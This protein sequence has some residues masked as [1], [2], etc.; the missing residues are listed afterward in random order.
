MQVCA[1]KPPTTYS[2]P[3][4]RSAVDIS[5]Y[6]NI[7][8]S[9]KL[10]CSDHI[11]G[12]LSIVQLAQAPVLPR[13]TVAQKYSHIGRLSARVGSLRYRS[14][15]LMLEQSLPSGTRLVHHQ[16]TPVRSVGALSTVWKRHESL[17]RWVHCGREIV[18]VL[19][20]ESVLLAKHGFPDGPNSRQLQPIEEVK[21]RQDGPQDLFLALFPLALE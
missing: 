19:S 16:R 18:D 14:L 20:I 10:T 3:S 5:R 4:K 8:R 6:A 9:K 12:M 13:A 21:T 2:P 7:G 17:S 11:L 1:G 15:E